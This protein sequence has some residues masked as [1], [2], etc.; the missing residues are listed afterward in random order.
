MQKNQR[1]I[2]LFRLHYRPNA[3]RDLTYYRDQT[4]RFTLYAPFVR[5]REKGD[6][7]KLQKWEYLG[8]K[9]QKWEFRN[10]SGESLFLPLLL[11]ARS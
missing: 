2:S 8:N 9:L 11:I 7:N 5:L 10:P 1:G 3:F 4:L 6:K